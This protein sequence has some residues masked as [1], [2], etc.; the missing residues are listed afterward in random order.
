[1]SAAE[2]AIKQIRLKGDGQADAA[3]PGADRVLRTA[4]GGVRCDA[5]QQ[6]R[7]DHQREL[8]H[9]DAD[10]DGIA[11]RERAIPLLDKIRRENVGEYGPFLSAVE[12]QA[13]MTIA[14]G[15]QAVAEGSTDAPTRRCGTWTGSCRRSTGRYAGLDLG[16]DARLR[17]LHDRVDQLWHRMPL[18]EHVFGIQPD[19]VNKTIVFEPHLPSGWEDIRIDDLPVGGNLV[20]FSRSRTEAGVIFRTSTSV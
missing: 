5:G 7:L 16:D 11:P 1:M 15:V 20:S 14:T 6:T 12:R 13:M 2:G 17:L 19:A 10:G 9:R 4:E 3:R 18:I 8:G